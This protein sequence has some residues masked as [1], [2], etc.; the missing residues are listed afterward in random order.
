MEEV[1][2]QSMSYTTS[3]QDSLDNSNPGFNPEL[4][5]H[6]FP[7]WMLKEEALK[8]WPNTSAIQESSHNQD[9]SSDSVTTSS[10]PETS[11]CPLSMDSL[12]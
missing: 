6:T 4:L 7:K 8:Y 3:C 12:D 9:S 11:N 1:C 2:R 10:A 5:M